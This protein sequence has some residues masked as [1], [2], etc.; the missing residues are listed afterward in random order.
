MVRRVRLLIY[1]AGSEERMEAQ[2]LGD[3]KFREW[4][5]AETRMSLTSIELDPRRITILELLRLFRREMT[6]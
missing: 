3:T 5:N 1:E 4:G 2:R 6:K